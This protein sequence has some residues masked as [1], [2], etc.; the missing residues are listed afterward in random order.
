MVSVENSN[1]QISRNPC[2]DLSS[3]LEQLPQYHA[4]EELSD[5]A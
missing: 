3:F 5:G 1:R 2:P 4:D